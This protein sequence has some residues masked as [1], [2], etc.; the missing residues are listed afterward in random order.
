MAARSAWKGYL[1]INLVS[2]PVKAYTSSSSGGSEVKLNQ[3][4]AD[5]NARIQ[6]KKF[7]LVHGEVSS[8]QI[9]SGYE[10]SKGQYAIIDTGELEKLRTEDDKAIRVNT[11]IAP[12]ALDPVY[13]SGKTHYLVPDG[14]VG[15][16]AYSVLHEAMVHQ[17]SYG[18]AQVVLHGKEQLVLLRPAGDLI[19]MMALQLDSEVTK[20]AAFA[21]EA[22]KAAFAPEE[23]KLMESL[24][25][26]ST[27]KKLDYSQYKDLYTERLTKLIEAKVAGQEL[28][29]PPVHE[30]AQVI[31]LMDALKQ[32]VELA[33]KKEGAKAG[34]VASKK[35]A[36]EAAVAP[37]KPAKKMAYIAGLPK[38]QGCV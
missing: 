34:V 36:K 11:F 22:P 12:D 8:D 25:K 2:V 13:F 23:L 38:P 27:V 26:A 32:S 7:C 14:P 20:P 3:L 15:Q 28:V 21:E 33:Q 4:H 29:A 6:Y 10:Y 17:G 1:Q 18:L 24:I 30:H 5:C 35:P 16:K 19:A 31:N 9:V 37:K